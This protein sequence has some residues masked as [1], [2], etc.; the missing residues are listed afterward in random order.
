[1]SSGGWK[2]RVDDQWKQAE[3]I[4]QTQGVPAARA[5]AGPL[6]LVARHD[7]IGSVQSILT[8]AS[9][10]QKAADDPASRLNDAQ[11]G[12]L[13]ARAQ[14]MTNRAYYEFTARSTGWQ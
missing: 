13:R 9:K 14:Y 10:M 7:L 11:R 12:N 5:F 8:E 2:A 1:M 3:H 4:A 6:G